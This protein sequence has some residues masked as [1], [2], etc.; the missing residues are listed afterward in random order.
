MNTKT[1][2]IALIAA[3]VILFFLTLD[4]FN[5]RETEIKPELVSGYSY[6]VEIVMKSGKLEI[7]YVELVQVAPPNGVFTE[8]SDYISILAGNMT[9]EKISFVMPTK[10]NRVSSQNPIQD[11]NHDRDVETIISIPVYELADKLEIYT[12][13]GNLNGTYQ[14]PQQLKIKK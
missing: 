13:N 12:A 7:T 1:Q 11:D 5:G 6:L 14:L 2:H 4:F 10:D 9:L 3:V 8:G